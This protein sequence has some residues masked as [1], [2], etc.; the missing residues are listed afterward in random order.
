MKTLILTPYKTMSAIELRLRQIEDTINDRS[1]RK[2]HR[3]PF[4]STD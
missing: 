2:L 3:N 4:H 1:L